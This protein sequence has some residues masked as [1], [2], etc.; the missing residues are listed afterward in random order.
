M[1][2]KIQWMDIFVCGGGM[3]KVELSWEHNVMSLE[4]PSSTEIPL[5][6]TAYN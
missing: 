1:L 4:A 5:I 6:C 3:G 2:P